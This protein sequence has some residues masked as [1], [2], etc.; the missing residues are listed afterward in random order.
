MQ[1]LVS[2][3]ELC[4]LRR[5]MCMMTTTML[6]ELSTKLQL[7]LHKDWNGFSILGNSIS[8]GKISPKF[9]KHSLDIKHYFLDI[10]NDFQVNNKLI[11][12]TPNRKIAFIDLCD[13]SNEDGTLPIFVHPFNSSLLILTC[14]VQIFSTCCLKFT[15][16]FSVSWNAL[17]QC[18]LP[19]MPPWSWENWIMIHFGLKMLLAFHPLLI[20][21]QTLLLSSFVSFVSLEF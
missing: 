11:D 5:T 3:L 2:N 7:L 1:C 21:R 9:P 14:S 10:A 4:I 15:L 6:L 13:F 12:V 20:V 17:R 16:L 8:L 18:V 19:S